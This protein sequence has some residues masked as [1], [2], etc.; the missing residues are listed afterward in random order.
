MQSE[1]ALPFDILLLRSP[2]APGAGAGA[3]A[4]VALHTGALCH[5]DVAHIRD[6]AEHLGILVRGCTHVTEPPILRP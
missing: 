4:G 2:L 3:S 5:G 1:K 6:V